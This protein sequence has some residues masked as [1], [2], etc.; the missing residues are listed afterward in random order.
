[1]TAKEVANLYIKLRQKG[2]SDTD[3]ADLIIFMETHTPSEKEAEDA[4]QFQ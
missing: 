3:I 2:W 1:M 4:K